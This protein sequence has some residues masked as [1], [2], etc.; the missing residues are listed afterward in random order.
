MDTAVLAAP[1]LETQ[2]L[3]AG[4]RVSG[5]VAWIVWLLTLVEVCLLL[6]LAAS[7][8]LDVRGL[9]ANYVVA[10]AAG[11]LAFG[12]V[13]ALIVS[14]GRDSSPLVG[15]LFCALGFGF[16]SAWLGEY[17][18]H[19]LVVEPGS[20]PAAIWPQWINSWLFPSL[21][22]LAAVYL[23]LVYPTGRLL[24]ARWRLLV[25]F[26]AVALL[27][28]TFTLA[29]SP[30]PVDTS[31]AQVPNPFAPPWAET[32][33]AVLT[34][35]NI[36]LVCLALAGGLVAAVVRYR[37]AAGLERQQ[38]KWFALGLA[39][40]LTA[41][42]VP[43]V[44][45]LPRPLEDSLLSGVCLSV[46]FLGIPVATGVAILRYRLFDV[47]RVIGHATVYTLLTAC[48]AGVYVFVVGYL[49]LLLHTADN[50]VV[51]LLAV[52]AVAVLVQPL[53]EHLQRLVNR[54]LYGDRDDPYRV[55]ARLGQ[56]LE[57]AAAQDAVLQTFTSTV[58]SALKLRYVAIA[59]PDTSSET[60]NSRVVAESGR[61]QS[62]LT[63]LPLLHQGQTVGELLVAPREPGEAWGRADRALLE[64]LAQQAAAAVHAL[65]LTEGLQ[66]LTLELQHARERLVLAREEE[67]R[68]LRHDLHDE[69]A[70]TLAALSLMSGRAADQLSSDLERA[71]GLLASVRDG[72]RAAV[73]DVRRLAYD[74]R[75]PILDELGLLA[76][77]QERSEQFS[78]DSGLR[79]IAHAAEPLP[80]LPAAVEVAA[81]RITLEALMNASRHAQA[82]ECR[83]ELSLVVVDG[84]QV[85]QVVV[86]DD[87]VGL[88]PGA[89]TGVGLASM[90]QRASE[91]G[92]TCRVEAGAPR[93]TRV[94]ARLPLLES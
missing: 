58:S 10:S 22:A 47:D 54:L 29:I 39:V 32:A 48:V 85:V 62:G 93:G 23:P 91:L 92:G 71:R 63:R 4:R 86:S 11:A 60:P 73:G 6:G 82:S 79:V 25:A 81:Y 46:G 30:G 89:A 40:N 31:V 20:L 90:R 14:R 43:I 9:F 44:V 65:Q 18:R 42:L 80:P 3:S 13:G 45:L 26:G 88:S 37:R 38:L 34:P 69:L 21:F 17:A 55:L 84:R 2:P 76:A 1:G 33:V 61:L 68:R 8:R 51:S 74:L 24:S 36:V 78:S 50:V 72:L 16:G 64:S 35:I 53:R 7:N 87:G 70:P 12:T 57:A 83:I 19:A 52:G 27:L 75:P 49:G 94:T 77:V 28:Q 67:R 66:R 56:Q 41:L 59:T 5:R 15:W